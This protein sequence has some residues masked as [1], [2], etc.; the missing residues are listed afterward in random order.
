MLNFDL[1]EHYA[2]G[3]KFNLLSMSELIN[4]IDYNIKNNKKTNIVVVNVFVL[5][6]CQKD[7]KFKQIINNA[8]IITIDGMPILW[9]LK[10][11]KYDVKEKLSGPDIFI[12]ILKLAEVKKYNVY[13]LGA[14]QEILEQM[15][16]NLKNKFKNLNISG[17]RNGYFDKKEE[18]IIIKNINNSSTDILFL[19][20]PSPAKERFIT[21]LD[22]NV[23]LSMGVGGVFDIEAG[24]VKRAPLWMQKSGLEW[25]YRLIQEPK[26]LWKRYFI[27]NT[28]FLKLVFIE[29][30]KKKE[31]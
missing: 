21:N 9:I 6:M 4:I 17:F 15:I 11:F 14:K 29:L 3:I 22:L 12:E 26:R 23:K 31:K 10:L 19:G 2:F 16:I 1:K 24:F 27:T 30:L 25:L 13:F 20:I 18:N 8:D 5:V 7:E 28:L